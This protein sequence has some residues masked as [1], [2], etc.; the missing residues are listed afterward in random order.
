MTPPNRSA[1]SCKHNSN[2]GH[3]VINLRDHVSLLPH[4]ERCIYTQSA[5]GRQQRLRAI[6]E[7][8]LAMLEDD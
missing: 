5:M 8:A 4:P 1:S 7:E 2:T 3:S 6:I